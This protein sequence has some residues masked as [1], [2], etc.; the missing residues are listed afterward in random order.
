MATRN[1]N[2][3]RS[4]FKA[5]EV[6][7]DVKVERGRNKGQSGTVVSFNEE[8]GQVEIELAN[9]NTI[10]AANGTVNWDRNP[11]HYDPEQ[12]EVGDSDDEEDDSIAVDALVAEDEETDEEEEE[13]PAPKA[14]VPKKVQKPCQCHCGDMASKGRMF[15]PGHDQIHK[16]NLIT[17]MQDGSEEAETELRNRKWRTD[18]EI[19]QLKSKARNGAQSARTLASMLPDL[20]D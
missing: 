1:A 17:A 12:F 10:V 15:L 20:D 5:F 6:G 19:I 9:G 4:N 11:F 13:A 3:K 2:I 14:V 18:N 16:G 8:T 7:E